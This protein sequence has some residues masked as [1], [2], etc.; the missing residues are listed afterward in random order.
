MCVWWAIVC[1]CVVARGVWLS[2][3]SGCVNVGLARVCGCGVDRDV[4][5]RFF[6]AHMLMAGDLWVCE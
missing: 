2:G 5:D 1:G 4:W 3:G 6:L